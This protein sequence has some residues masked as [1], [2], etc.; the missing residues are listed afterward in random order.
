MVR[1]KFM[2]RRGRLGCFRPK[3]LWSAEPWTAFW[4]PT[5]APFDMKEKTHPPSHF[6]AK[7][8][9]RDIVGLG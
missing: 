7:I 9:K 1:A 5:S 8:N 6:K 3:S 4:I 2:E